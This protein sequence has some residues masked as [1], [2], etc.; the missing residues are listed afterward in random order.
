MAFNLIDFSVGRGNYNNAIGGISPAPHFYGSEVD[1]LAVITASGYFN[2]AAAQLPDSLRI[3]DKL[4]IR[5]SADALAIFKIVTLSPNVTVKDLA[6]EGTA[7]IVEQGRRTSVG[8]SAVET[9]SSGLVLPSDNIFLMLRTEG[10]VSVTILAADAGT[11][12]FNVTF[13]ADPS[14]D[15]QFTF[16]AIRDK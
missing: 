7:F 15:H 10:A 12:E 8:G 4:T 13:S 1:L 2:E 14:N 11:A 5:D 9:F 3:G 6:S 16:M